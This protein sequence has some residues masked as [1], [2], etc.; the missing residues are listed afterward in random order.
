VG[1]GRA[2]RSAG[3]RLLG[4]LVASVALLV[5]PFAVLVRTAVWAHQGPGAGA[6]VAVLAGLLATAGVLVA[7]AAVAGRWLGVGP[8]FG[9]TLRW[10]SVGAGV[11][12]VGWALLWLG[13]AQAKSPEVR[14]EYHSLHPVLRLATSTVFLVDPWRVVTDA[15]REPEDYALMDLPQAESSLHFVQEDGFVH[16][17]DLRTRGRPEWV[18]KA[19]ELGFWAL[20]FY[21]L[22]HRG[23]ADHLHVSLRTG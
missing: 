9:R 10:S 8:G 21:A 22:R 13:A 17:V 11:V 19:V 14:A 6:W 16:A 23:T 5:L 20:G 15:S 3:R 4:W 7:Y 1:V 18:N 12:F 2:L